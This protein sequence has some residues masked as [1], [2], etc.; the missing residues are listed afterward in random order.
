M[1]REVQSSDQPR[2]TLALSHHTVTHHFLC[3]LYLLLFEG[4]LL[5]NSYPENWSSLLP[6]PKSVMCHPIM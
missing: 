6:L 5:F 1:V 4:S 2:G 3:L